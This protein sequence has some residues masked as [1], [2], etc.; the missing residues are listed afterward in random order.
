MIK[1]SK[2]FDKK[3]IFITGGTGTF[4]K[5]MINYLLKVSKIIE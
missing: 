4:G 3:N 5:A 2:F 1:N